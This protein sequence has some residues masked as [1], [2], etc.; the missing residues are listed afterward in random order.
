MNRVFV[1]YLST[2][3]L[4]LSFALVF[5][6]VTGSGATENIGM[7]SFAPKASD[8]DTDDDG[9]ADTIEDSL[10]TDETDK[11]G[12]FDGDGLY[13]FEEYLDLY[14]T[15]DNDTDVPRYSYN[16]SKTHGDILDIYHYFDL[17]TSK[18][19]WLR[20]NNSTELASDVIT[21][22]LLWNVTFSESTSSNI[23]YSGNL[24]VES[25]FLGNYSGGSQHGQTSYTNNTLRNVT[26]GGVGSGGTISGVVEYEANIFEHVY[27]TG[28]GAGGASDN[29]TVS[30]RNNNFTEVHFTGNNAGLNGKM[31]LSTEYTGNLFNNVEYS[32][33]KEAQISILGSISNEISN[34]SY[35][36]D[37]D[38]LGD[39][40]ELLISG[41]NPVSWDTDTD[42]L[43]DS[44]ETKYIESSGVDPLIEATDAELTSDLDKDNLTLLKEAELFTDPSNNDT[45]N[46][47][48]MD[49]L[50][51][52]VIGSD[53][54]Q[55]DTDGDY[56]TDAFEYYIM[57]TDPTLYDTDGDD[58]GDGVEYFS[59]WTNPLLNDT[60]GDGLSD[61]YEY[62]VLGTDPR[63][64][65]T[66]WDGLSDS[67]ELTENTDP[68]LNDTDGD[69]L[70]DG[71][72]V[73]YTGSY[74]V[75][76]V[77][78]ANDTELDSD[79]D[80]DNLT[81]LEEALFSSDPNEFDT[82][83]DGLSDGYEAKIV[84]TNPLR[85]DTDGDGL[86][87]SYELLMGS[88]PRYF[89]TD[90]DDLND[91]YELQ[92]GSDPTKIDTDNDGLTDSY[93]L[94]FGTDPSL[95]DTDG[96]GLNDS[97]EVLI[98]LTNPLSNDSDADGL[99]DHWEVVYNGS[100][101]VNPL[102]K[103]NEIELLSDK[104][105]DGL[106]LLEEE[107]RNTDPEK[108][109]KRSE[110]DTIQDGKEDGKAGNDTTDILETVDPHK[111][112][113][114]ST[115]EKT[116]DLNLTVSGLSFAFLIPLGIIA[117]LSGLVVIVRLK[118]ARV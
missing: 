2:I 87:D 70:N 43:S 27:F 108:S 78:P 103:A 16:D 77:I 29:G 69:G 3:V 25:V 89:D 12:D 84:G 83:S 36:T 49:G 60:D 97:S 115:E 66:D 73:H 76:P 8:I 51:Y 6:M 39:V 65:D 9:I 104:D 95:F 75:N 35:D 118:K 26:F 28:T 116:Q 33:V 32:G 52:Y 13:D 7:N 37:D 21:D 48:L 71:W 101:G 93:E 20:D 86:N 55:Q 67:D 110:D 112:N 88:D 102:I 117:I 98:H 41:T 19:G 22:Y 54:L 72:E 42:G 38:G 14:G 92:I 114:N 99:G 94:I 58:I 45:D 80:N 100:F 62:Y 91:S 105:S 5:S 81:L 113:T 1:N 47:V 44:W 18:T 30:Y 64:H 57:K 11:Y 23:S 68:I 50:E 106:T 53:P 34:D 85:N 63:S 111:T 31:A 74:G 79:L 107:R 46:D 40:H 82:D 4:A 61:G 24:I 10:G 90:G 109:D 59:I 15:P 56:V 96:D 17:N